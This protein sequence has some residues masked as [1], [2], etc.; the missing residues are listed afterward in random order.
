M[1]LSRV[2]DS[3]RRRLLVDNKII[4]RMISDGVLGYDPEL[5][6]ALEEVIVREG[7]DSEA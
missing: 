7:R 4:N 2:S 6:W 5:S 1:F 3:T